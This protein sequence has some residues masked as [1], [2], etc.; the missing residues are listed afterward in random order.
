MTSVSVIQAIISIYGSSPEYATFLD[1]AFAGV[2]KDNTTEFIND[3]TY[4]QARMEDKEMSNETNAHQSTFLRVLG[5]TKYK[6]SLER[7]RC[8]YFPDERF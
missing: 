2:M 7:E 6:K 5:E 3:L 1:S 4:L 8:D